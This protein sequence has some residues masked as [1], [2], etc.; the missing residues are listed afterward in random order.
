MSSNK[1]TNSVEMIFEKVQTGSVLEELY[2]S[3]SYIVLQLE[4][5]KPKSLEIFICIIF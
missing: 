4:E 5:S 3:C 1:Y 2:S